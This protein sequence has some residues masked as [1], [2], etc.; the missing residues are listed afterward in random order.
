MYKIEK[1]AYISKRKNE[2]II[3]NRNNGKWIKIS[4][5]RLDEINYVLKNNNDDYIEEKYNSLIAAGIVSKE[6]EVHEDDGITSVMIAITNRCNLNCL[7]CG[8]S[9]H[10]GAKDEISLSDI[11]RIISENPHLEE[12]TITGGEPL[13]HSQICELL[14][15][16]SDNFN[17]RKILMTNATLIKED[18]IQAVIRTFDHIAISIDGARESTVDKMRGK[19]AYRKILRAIELLKG[20]QFENISLSMTLTEC[21][22]N[23][24]EDFFKL[25][26]KLEVKPELRDLFIVGRAKENVDVLYSENINKMETPIIDECYMDNERRHLQL[27]G[28]CEAGRRNVYIQYDGRIYPCPVAATNQKLLLGQIKDI[29]CDLQKLKK[30]ECYHKG[31]NYLK[32]ISPKEIKKCKDCDVNEFCWSCLQDYYAYIEDEKNF[33]VFCE[34]RKNILTKLVWG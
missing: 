34:Q 16:L 20:K 18:I 11:K 17:G 3:G 31:C 33:N 13:V 26:E 32:N 12:V 24:E 2:Y 28:R 15:F 27:T 9:A 8:F 14:D 30:T 5:D 22:Y 21:N 29:N 4:K 19:G 7:H 1:S 25:C 23:E 10:M 6:S